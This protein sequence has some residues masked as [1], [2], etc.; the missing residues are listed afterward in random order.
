MPRLDAYFFRLLARSLE[1]S[2]SPDSSAHAVKVWEK[3]RSAAIRE[4]WFAAGGL[5]DGVLSL[6]LAEIVAKLPPDV[7]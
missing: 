4:N 6:H 5:E 7:L 2:G 1:E 3:F